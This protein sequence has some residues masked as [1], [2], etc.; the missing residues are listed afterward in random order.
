[1]NY[2]CIKIISSFPPYINRDEKLFYFLQL[3][4]Q[5][6]C[7]PDQFPLRNVDKTQRASTE[8]VTCVLVLKQ[9]FLCVK[10]VRWVLGGAYCGIVTIR[11]ADFSQLK[12][13]FRSLRC[14]VNDTLSYLRIHVQQTSSRSDRMVRGYVA[15]YRGNKEL[16]CAAVLW[17]ILQ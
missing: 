16:V 15:N 11:N 1:M 13:V 3:H 14:R 9:S 8:Y 7:N 5:R 2:R 4:L 6:R 10:D 17:T 12:H